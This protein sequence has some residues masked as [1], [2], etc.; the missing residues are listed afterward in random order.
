M[1]FAIFRLIKKDKILITFDTLLKK[2]K[3]TNN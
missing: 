3:I 2:E 1:I